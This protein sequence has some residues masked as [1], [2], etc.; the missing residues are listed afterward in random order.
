MPPAVHDLRFGSE[1]GSCGLMDQRAPALGWKRLHEDP[2]R[3]RTGDQKGG[4]KRSPGRGRDHGVRCLFA[5]TFQTFPVTL[6][7]L[8]KLCPGRHGRFSRR[9]TR[10]WLR[11]RCEALN[12][13]GRP[14]RPMSKTPSRPGQS[15]KKAVWVAM[16]SANMVTRP[17]IRSAKPPENPRVAFRPDPPHSPSRTMKMSALTDAGLASRPV[18]SASRADLCSAAYL[19]DHELHDRSE[20]ARSSVGSR[21]V[22]FAVAREGSASVAARVTARASSLGPVFCLI[23][24]IS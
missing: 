3:A 22:V 19:D 23:F 1:P 24:S 13:T 7:R 20:A 21:R 8:Q 4:G 11:F 9:S 16:Q 14:P 6:R 10:A 15:T 5:G 12:Q 2:W 17:V 18:V